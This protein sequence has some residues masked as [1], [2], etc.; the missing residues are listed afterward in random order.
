MYFRNIY[1]ILHICVIQMTYLE[2]INLHDVES[3][4]VQILYYIPREVEM[5][6]FTDH[7]RAHSE[8]LIEIIDD[9]LEVCLKSDIE[10]NELERSL[11]YASAWLHD[12]GC[13]IARKDHSIESVKL[14]RK[15]RR[16]FTAVDDELL[17]YLEWIVRSHQKSQNIDE[18]PKEIRYHR[19]LIKLRFLS[20]IFRLAD[21]CDIDSK[22]APKVVFDIIKDELSDYSK[23]MWIAHSNVVSIY[24]DYEEKSI[25]LHLSNIDNTKIVID[26]LHEDLK[27][28][29]KILLEYG[30]LCISIKTIDVASVP[31]DADILS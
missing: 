30:F 10:I 23:E 31:I 3:Q 7:G 8:R 28:I 26:A 2:Y 15:Y 27:S 11:L 18:V 5:K 9:I 20:A 4:V 16:Y 6:N 24:F 21:A 29:E 14:L 1:S 13:L 12:I 17:V 25:T 19:I 22:R